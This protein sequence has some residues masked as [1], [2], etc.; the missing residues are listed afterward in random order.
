[1][2]LK[3]RVE[4]RKNMVYFFRAKIREMPVGL[5]GA[6]EC[7]PIKSCDM[8]EKIMQDLKQNI[9]EYVEEKYPQEIFQEDEI[10]IQAFNRL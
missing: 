4:R 9:M 8:F 2:L 1:M 7:E 10:S 5:E 3:S 6:I